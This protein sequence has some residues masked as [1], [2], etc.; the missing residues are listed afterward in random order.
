MHGRR[1]QT[2]HVIL[3]SS[4]C[5]DWCDSAWFSTSG[6]SANRFNL[7]TTI[8]K[9]FSF[10]CIT[11]IL[12]ESSLAFQSASSSPSQWT[13][14]NMVVASTTLDSTVFDAMTS[15]SEQQTKTQILQLGAALD[16]GQA[17]NPTSGDY[18]KEC[19]LPRST[20][21]HYSTSIYR[22]LRL[23]SLKHLSTLPLNFQTIHVFGTNCH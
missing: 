14:L 13:S 10:L 4:W 22:Q 9:S 3:H 20:H 15:T 12:L 6:I 19:K 1:S 21:L 23:S 17:Y 5:D 11:F 8:M 7:F 18:Y 16:R 2:K